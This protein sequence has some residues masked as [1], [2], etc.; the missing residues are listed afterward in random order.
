MTCLAT[1]EAHAFLTRRQGRWVPT[2]C[3]FAYLAF[4]GFKKDER[5][6][7]FCGLLR[8][9]G[10]FGKI[11]KNYRWHLTLPIDLD[12]GDVSQEDRTDRSGE[13]V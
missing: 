4:R 2:I 13:L 11:D 12:D 3:I 10:I 5:F 9:P 1:T 6:R 8:V 7:G